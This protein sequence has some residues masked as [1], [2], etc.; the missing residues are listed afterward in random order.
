VTLGQM[1]ALVLW[2]RRR[3]IIQVLIASNSMRRKFLNRTTIFLKCDSKNGEKSL[4]DCEL[5]G[6]KSETKV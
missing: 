5:I 6:Q 1:L 2:L 3:A 4:I